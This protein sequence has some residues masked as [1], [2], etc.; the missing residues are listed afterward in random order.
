M[1]IIEEIWKDIK[2]YEGYYQISNY[3]N[4]KSLERI[5]TRKDGI[6]Q[7]RKERIMSKRF[8]TDG[9]VAA[10]LNVN[11]MSKSIAVHIL[12]ATHF[13]PNPNNYPEVNHKDCNR[14]NNRVDNLEWCTHQQNVEYSKKLGHYKMPC[15]KLNP[16]YGNHILSER[17]KNNPELAKEINSRPREQNGRCVPIQ[18]I[19]NSTVYSFKFIGEA[20]EYLIHNGYTKNKISTIRSRIIKS[21]KDNE[22]YLGFNFKKV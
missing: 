17:Y 10:K 22:Q 7:V 11:R 13:I 19:D 12:V 9:Y 6:I 1:S 2:G 15:G 14:T 8:T 16:N 21:I 4:V 18:M 5:V 3:G 20:A